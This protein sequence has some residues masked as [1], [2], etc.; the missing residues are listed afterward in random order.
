M[1]KIYQRMR[2]HL[3][4]GQE[5]EGDQETANCLS[6]SLWL[7]DQLLRTFDVRWHG[8]SNAEYFDKLCFFVMHW[9]YTLAYSALLLASSQ[10]VRIL[11]PGV[12]D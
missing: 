5:E 12:F 9:T 7:A 2:I 11:H 8:K 6:I 4:L 3:A 10:N 1:A